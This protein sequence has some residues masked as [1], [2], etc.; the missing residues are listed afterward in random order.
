MK[1]TIATASGRIMDVPTVWEFSVLVSL[2]EY[3]TQVIMFASDGIMYIPDLMK[4][5][6]GTQVMLG[7]LP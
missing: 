6:S 5:V 2:T 1:W 7:L 4:I 3:T